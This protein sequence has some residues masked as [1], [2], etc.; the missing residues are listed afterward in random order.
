MAMKFLWGGAVGFLMLAFLNRR[1]VPG[2]GWQRVWGD[3]TALLVV[4]VGWGLLLTVTGRF[5]TSL[6]LGLGLIGLLAAG[7]GLKQKL[8]GEPLVFSDV[9]LAGHALRWPRLY[10][11]YVPVGVWL[12]L[13][14]AVLGLTG[15]GLA[16]PAMATDDR[17]T[18]VMGW[19]V[20]LAVVVAW[21]GVLWAGRTRILAACPLTFDAAADAARYTALGEAVLQTLNHV[22]NAKTVAAEVSADRAPAQRQSSVTPG[23]LV[24]IQAESFAP[25]SLYLNRPSVTPMLDTLAHEGVSGLLELAWRGAYTMRTEFSV[26][27]G[28]KATDTASWSFDPYRLAE[29]VPLAT[30]ACDLKAAG[31]DTV[32]WHPNDGRFFNRNAVMPHLGFD[33]F[34]DVRAFADLRRVDG[35]VTDEALLAKAGRFLAGCT[36]PTFLF[37]VT[38]EAHGPWGGKNAEDEVRAYEKHLVSL[39]KSIAKLAAAVR[40]LPNA[41]LALYGDHLPGLK[42]LA[43]ERRTATGWMMWP[44]VSAAPSRMEPRNLRA[45]LR[46]EVLG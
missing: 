22:V 44:A 21:L 10:F 28:L 15:M 30:L 41:R 45:F 24:L 5:V 39:D 17:Q 29:R 2:A 32:A 14:V 43:H 3:A 18:A 38:M 6:V 35:K 33:R 37:I 4:F 23:H 26:L 11:G 1:A 7:N 12:G 8:L 9:F 25:V 19:L 16:E 27:T 40:S 36:K 20:S 42:A 31:Y 34:D 13:A 46:K